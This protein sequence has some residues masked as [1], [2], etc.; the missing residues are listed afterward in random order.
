MLVGVCPLLNAQE[1]RM[2]FALSSVRSR[3]N[4]GKIRLDINVIWNKYRGTV[5]EIIRE[6]FN[7]RIEKREIDLKTR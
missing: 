2:S 4:S 7:L 5:Q 1:N 6:L 3:F